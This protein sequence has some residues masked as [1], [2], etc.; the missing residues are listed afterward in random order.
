MAARSSRSRSTWSAAEWDA[1]EAEGA[2]P[3]AAQEMERQRKQALWRWYRFVVDQ[4]MAGAHYE[5]AVA[6]LGSTR[7]DL[8]TGSEAEHKMSPAIVER[9][10]ALAGFVQ[11]SRQAI[12]PRDDPTLQS[13]HVYELSPSSSA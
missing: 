12:G 6:E 3:A 2:V 1:Y 8:I 5:V 4:A 11:R 10:L 9:E 13:F 7:D